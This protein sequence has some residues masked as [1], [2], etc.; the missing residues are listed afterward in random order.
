MTN[1]HVL[2]VYDWMNNRPER[3]RI[4]ASDV[5]IQ[6]DLIARV[7]GVS[8]AEG[9]FLNLTNDL[10]D[11][12]TYGALLNAYVHSRSR[13]KAESLLEVMRSKRYLIHSLPFNLMMTLYMNLKD[14]DKVDMLVSEMKE[15]NI[16]LDI[17]T[18]NIWLSSCGSQGSIQKME[19][20]F[21]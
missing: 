18:Y 14:Y 19:Q 17:Y 6:L 11:K 10:K 21:E 16:Q 1:E 8:S 15:K 13:E 3:F 4:S 20:V 12:R 5:A 9:F 7:H 2:Q